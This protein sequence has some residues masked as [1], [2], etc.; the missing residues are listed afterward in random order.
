LQV[1]RPNPFFRE[2]TVLKGHEFHYSRILPDGDVP[3]TAFSVLRGT[4]CYDGRDG[5]IS[6]NVLA[7]YIHLHAAAAPEWAQGLLDA[8]QRYSKKN[9]FEVFENADLSK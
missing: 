8:A 5:V 2:G 4:G 7:G 9:E 6:G 1:D 3:P